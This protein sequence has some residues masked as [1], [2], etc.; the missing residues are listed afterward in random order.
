MHPLESRSSLELPM[1]VLWVIQQS[2]TM[3]GFL[4][5]VSESDDVQT[6]DTLLEHPFQDS[7]IE[8]H[9]AVDLCWLLTWSI[10]KCQD[11][12]SVKSIKGSA[13]SPM[14]TQRNKDKACR[15]WPVTLEELPNIP[16]ATVWRWQVIV[17]TRMNQNRTE[18]NRS[19]HRCLPAAAASMYKSYC[20]LDAWLL[21]CIML[22]P[23]DF[24]PWLAVKV[25]VYTLFTTPVFTCSVFLCPFYQRRLRMERRMTLAVLY[26][27]LID[28]RMP[29]EAQRRLVSSW[30][31]EFGTSDVS[32][33]PG[34]GCTRMNSF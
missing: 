10:V 19:S 13:V 12:S 23:Q 20:V 32:N 21:M 33:T 24:L 31:L 2:H 15:F 16:Q 17:W 5:K 11:F 29:F 9:G 18:L 7:I 4:N 22:T 30:T 34:H 8:G 25:E 6:K 3:A 14:F 26:S 27:L 1:I 28:F